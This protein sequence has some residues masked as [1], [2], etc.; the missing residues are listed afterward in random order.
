MAQR[1][2]VKHGSEAGYREEIKTDNVCERCRNGHRVFDTQYTKRGKAKNLKYGRYDVIDHLYSPD[3]TRIV[4]EGFSKRSAATGHS[5]AGDSPEGHTQAPI[6]TAPDSDGPGSPG[7]RERLSDALFSMKTERKTDDGYVPI[8][9][10]PDYIHPINP[11]PEP[12]SEDWSQVKPDEFVITAGEFNQIRDNLGTYL[13]TVGMTIGIIDPYCG[14]I[15]RDNL[16][17]TVNSWA[18]VITHYPTA[19][20][21]FMAKGG[22]KIMA[23]IDALISTWPIL[24][25]IYE[26]HLAHTVKIDSL[27]RAIKVSKADAS[28]PNGHFATQPEYNYTVE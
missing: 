3:N 17:D 23:W 12:T 21:V 22:G 27:G 20:K 5:P 14:T 7:L 15:L 16:D 8:D 10:T 26:H 9:E 11:D 1:Q 13:A 28:M 18:R 4:P 25:A 6:S 24:L 19:A 2:L